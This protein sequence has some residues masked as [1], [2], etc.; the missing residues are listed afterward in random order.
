MIRWNSVNGQKKKPRH[1][2]FSVM[3]LKHEECEKVV[4]KGWHVGSGPH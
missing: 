4:R 2:C 3:W 1:L